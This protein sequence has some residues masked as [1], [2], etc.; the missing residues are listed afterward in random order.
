[1]V[2]FPLLNVNG[3]KG[4]NRCGLCVKATFS[5][6]KLIP[7]N[8]QMTILYTNWSLY[9]TFSITN[10]CFKIDYEAFWIRSLQSVARIQIYPG[11]FSEPLHFR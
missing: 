7:K 5:V 2:K 3:S 4:R 10:S 6:Q 11:T 9:V 8:A 1:M